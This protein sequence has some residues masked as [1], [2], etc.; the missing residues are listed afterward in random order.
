MAKLI[1]KEDVVD[2]ANDIV[3]LETRH[4]GN[5]IVKVESFSY[6]FDGEEETPHSVEISRFGEHGEDFEMDEYGVT[7]RLWEVYVET[8]FLGTKEGA[9]WAT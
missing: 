6:R 8:C 7:W 5:D 9:P 3:F 1:P 2:Y 4:C